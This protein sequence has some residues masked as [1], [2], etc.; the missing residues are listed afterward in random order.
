M[1]NFEFSLHHLLIIGVLSLSFSISAM[2]RSQAADYGF[3]LNEFDPFFN[4]RAT[5]YIVE[6]GL[7]EYAVWH[8]DMSWY[9]FG[10]DV[11]RTSQVMLHVTAAILYQ[12]F[13]AGSDLYGFTIIFPVVFGSLT[14]I[15]VFALVRVIGG[16]TAGLFA[17]LFY[18]VS[19]PIIT[20]GTIGWFKSEPLGLFYGILALYLFLSGLKSSS[21]KIAAAKLIGGGIMLGFAFS[22][23][24]GTEF[25]V[26]PLGMFM[27]TLPFLRKDNN[28]LIW[29]IPVFILG[30]AISLSPLE[31][32]GLRFFVTAGGFMLVGPMLFVIACSF[33]QKVKPE[34]ANRNSA[35]L[36]IA[37]IVGGLAILSSDAIGMP[38]FRYLNAVN[39]FLTTVDPLVDSVAEHATKSIFQSFLFNSVFMIFG[40]I[41]AWLIFRNMLNPDNQR[42]DVHAFALIF[43]LLGV[44]IS[45]AFIRLEMY[46]SLSL[47]ILGAVGLSIL[48][49]EM[50]RVERKENKKTIRAHPATMKIS[51]IAIIVALFISPLM[52]PADTNWVS[53]A[54]TPPTIL[55]GGSNYNIATSDWLEA[56]AWLKNNTPQDAVVASWWDYGYWITTLGERR[57]IADNATLI[58]WRIKQMAQILLG[59]PDES[60]RMLQE[61]NADYILVYV[62]A[63]RINN[64]DPPLFF[65][66]GGGDES[67]K[68]WFMRIGGFD[69]TRYVYN[70]GLSSTPEFWNETLLGKMIPFTTFAYVDLVNQRQSNSYLPGFTPVY[71]DDIKFPKDGNGP[72]RLAYMSPGFTRTNAG[73]INGVLIYEVNKD[74]VPTVAT[75]TRT[76][77]I[78]SVEN[79]SRNITAKT[80]TISTRFGEIVVELKPDVAPNTVANF[81]KLANS[82]F[83]DG[84][85]FHRIIAD[86]MIQG[87]DPNTKSEPPQTWGTGGPGYSINA[88]LSDIKHTKYIVSMARGSDI[89]SAGS[90]FFIMVGDAPWLDGKYTV[91]GEV[92]EG[93]DVVDKIAALQT[94]PKDQPMDTESARIISIR[95]N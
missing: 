36:L 11:M 31:R 60:W 7:S 58:D 9:P 34:R 44:Y 29:A 27:M 94:N 43:G 25:L 28:F 91:F 59:S 37:V 38:S 73:P 75:P 82:N 33:L 62:A 76:D 23:W 51:F 5:A 49:K 15:V 68:Q 57:S 1:G 48:A 52:I 20:R 80:A 47:L 84:T 81:V 35:L 4:Y 40:G 14:A 69:E 13:G 85:L 67:K 83:Y 39:P 24:G 93:K 42:R 78:D 53:G 41:G 46:S 74:Y 45:S 64:E 92:I 63:Q 32:P 18:A 61:M 6:N 10:R 56:M 17:S 87:G 50:F 70:D 16:T 65:V 54:K 71:I 26:L 77:M 55:N 72:L 2:I 3:Q 12:M 19:L 88:E 90:Q 66:Q 21:K 8:D 89:N 79:D 30:L 95:V 86:F 22:S